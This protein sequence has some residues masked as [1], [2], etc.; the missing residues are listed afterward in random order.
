VALENG[1]R[2]FFRLEQDEDGYPPVSWE[3]LWAERGPD[4]LYC[5]DNVPFYAKGVSSGDVVAVDMV[6][7]ELVFRELVRAS[8]NSVV[9]VYV[10]QLEDVQAARDEF[11]ALG[12]H[13][14]LSDVRRLFAFEVPAQTEFAPIGRLIDEGVHQNRWEY[15]V[16]VMRHRV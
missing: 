13:S 5:L 7:D 1:A 2:V 6:G 10:L 15:E 8:G 9:R 16:G 4:G 12:C 11:R 3:R 14:E